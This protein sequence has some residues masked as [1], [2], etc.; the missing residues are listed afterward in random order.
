MPTL[1]S[2]ISP[3]LRRCGRSSPRL[4][5]AV[6]FLCG[7]VAAVRAQEA[8]VLP[9][10]EGAIQFDGVVDE[11]AWL[12][13][14]PVPLTTTM[15]AYGQPPSLPTELRI[16]YDD[17]Y[18]Y[19]GARCAAAEDE[20][21]GP[22]FKRDFF[23]AGADY[24]ALVLDTFGDNEN[25][26]VFAVMPTGARLDFTVFNDAQGAAPVN[27]DWNAF[28]D[29]AVARSDTGWSV[30]MRIPFSSLRFR[31]D[32]GRVVMG[33]IAWRWFARNAEVATFP[34]IEPTWGFWSFV[35]PSR[36][37]AVSL[38]GVFSRRPFY[39]APYLLSGVSQWHELDGAGTGYRRVGEPTYDVGLDVKY[40]LTSDLTLDVT[41]NTDFAQVEADDHQVNLTRFSLFFPEKRVFFQ[42]RASLFDFG[43]AEPSSLFDLFPFT[44]NRL[45]YSRRVGLHDGQAV[46]ILGGARL[47][48]RL[49]G[50]D[51][52][53]LGMQ[54]A[55]AGL[56]GTGGD[57]PSEH[58]N[59]VRLR[60]PV[61]NPYSYGGMMATTRLGM[62]GRY[63]VAY[64][65]DG[66]LRLLGD[67]YLSFAVSQTVD[68]GSA[69]A[70]LLD[71]S[72]MQARWERRTFGGLG[73]DVSVS[74]SG[75]L[76]DPGVGFALRQDYTRIG[77]RLFYGWIP[78]E[79]SAL[80]R[81]QLSLNGALFL[82]NADGTVESGEIGP[83]WEASLKTGATVRGLAGY[84]FEEL[85]EP[86]DLGQVR[87]AAGR[88][89]FATV[90]VLYETPGGRTLRL[91]VNGTAGSFFGGQR[92]SLGAEPRWMMSRHLELRGYY[93]IDRLHFPEA[94]RTFLA[95]VARVRAA[96]ALNTRLSADAF[97]QY[98]SAA[99]A[100]AVNV[101]LRY[102]PR[103]G[104]DLYLVYN[105]GL[106]ADRHRLVPALPVTDRRTLVAKYTYTFPF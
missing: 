100:A 83:A 4:F 45:F 87:I 94:G 89:R 52:G 42:E 101:R 71:L 11:A 12:P 13:I 43:P 19:L 103:E 46:P 74:R 55:A 47:V 66:T 41:V 63:D 25:A 67:D 34:A 59:V 20:V 8:V 85:R 14:E 90:Q 92:L 56:V 96:A 28:W 75:R 18:L 104:N 17:A 27:G 10:L 16:A 50:W 102:N 68:D 5:L 32:G 26:V 44:S 9:R 99:D 48:G 57:L 58:F 7:G 79:G 80:Q 40:G 29:A 3:A 76:Y 53:L 33:L 36:A 64:G 91:K 30:E 22:S 65:L 86:F 82:R 105:Q 15:P 6:L 2:D 78:G 72:R 70:A 38:D 73:Y 35:K 60:R 49:G 97:V 61:L 23:D 106:N 84:F 88:H 77:D 81:H 1:L 95:H 98:S 51:V 93:G 31:D 21:V 54:T 24:V 39:V 62:D 37:R 69:G